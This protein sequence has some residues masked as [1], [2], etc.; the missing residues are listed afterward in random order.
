[1]NGFSASRAALR[2]AC[3]SPVPR[4]S[5][6]QNRGAPWLVPSNENRQHRSG[7][8]KAETARLRNVALYCAF[9]HALK[10]EV[11]VE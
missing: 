8:A 4:W 6:R 3:R 7:V 9:Q 1:M 5:Y 11:E 10:F 2:R